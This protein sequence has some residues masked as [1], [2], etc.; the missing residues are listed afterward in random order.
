MVADWDISSSVN[1]LHLL[2][3]FISRRLTLARRCPAVAERRW[4][5]ASVAFP[6]ARTYSG[7]HARRMKRIKLPGLIAG[8]LLSFS[9]VSSAQ[10]T[11]PWRAASSTA[12]AITGDIFIGDGKL[13]INF[14]AFPLAKIRALTPTEISAAFDAGLNE[15]GAGNLY[16]LSIPAAKRFLHHNTLCGSEETQWMATYMMNRRL[17]VALFSGEEMPVL[18]FDALANGTNVCGT[19]SYER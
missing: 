14:L 12:K 19:F 15:G 5:A 8:C 7:C 6:F 16:R 2:K 18:T 3:G 4:L 9:L 13:D 10:D 11:G 1:S 17:H